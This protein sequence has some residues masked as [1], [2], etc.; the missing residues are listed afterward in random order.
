MTRIATARRRQFV[1][2]A[3]RIVA[4]ALSIAIS[5]AAYADQK[6]DT[7]QLIKNI[8]PFTGIEARPAADWCAMVEA[9]RGEQWWRIHE[10]GTTTSGDSG[11][12]VRFRQSL[13]A[14]RIRLVYNISGQNYIGGFASIFISLDFKDPYPVYQNPISV[15]DLKLSGTG[16]IGP[17]FGKVYFPDDETKS[18]IC[19]GGLSAFLHLIFQNEF[20]DW[21]R[22]PIKPTSGP[23]RAAC[24]MIAKRWSGT[25]PGMT[26]KSSAWLA[27]L[28]MFC[29]KR[30]TIRTQQF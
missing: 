8:F 11:E 27:S 14:N 12:V 4:L 3:L 19:G 26:T 21:T 1:R 29:S 2:E 22:I 13:Y 17:D 9:D 25:L 24:R 20:F 18:T 15:Q 10:T 6:D 7:A 16:R 23:T 30:E 28:S 5:N